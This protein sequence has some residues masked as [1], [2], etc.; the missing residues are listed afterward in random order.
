MQHL[1]GHGR[2]T[3]DDGTD[4]FHR[5]SPGLDR[6]EQFPVQ[7]RHTRQG[8]HPGDDRSDRLA[9][10]TIAEGQRPHDHVAEVHRIAGFIQVL[11]SVPERPH[12]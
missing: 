9:L 4:L 11:M 5:G 1:R 2:I 10:Q 12:R 8:P 3:G 6:A 7:G